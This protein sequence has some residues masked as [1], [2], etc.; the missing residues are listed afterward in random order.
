VPN[1]KPLVAVYAF[2]PGTL[3]NG[4]F[5]V[6]QMPTKAATI[7][8][9]ADMLRKSKGL[10]AGQHVDGKILPPRLKVKAVAR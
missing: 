6:P 8:V 2:V 4:T 5:L 1:K 9:A 10:P 7:L 3:T